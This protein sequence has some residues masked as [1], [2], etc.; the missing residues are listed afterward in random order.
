MRDRHVEPEYINWAYVK[1]MGGIVNGERV[2]GNMPRY[3]ALGPDEYY[4]VMS[5]DRKYS[6]FK[7]IDGKLARKKGDKYVPMNESL[8]EDDSIEWFF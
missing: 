7:F 1:Q 5:I 3:K 8:T 6:F 2:E 4:V